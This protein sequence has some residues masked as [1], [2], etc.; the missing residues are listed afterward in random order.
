MNSAHGRIED[1]EPVNPWTKRI[2]ISF[3]VPVPDAAKSS[4]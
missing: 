2:P 1:G 3:V 4:K